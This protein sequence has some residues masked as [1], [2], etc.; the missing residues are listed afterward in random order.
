MVSK[1]FG[2]VFGD[3]GGTKMAVPLRDYLTNLGHEVKFAVDGNGKGADVLK[4]AK[5]NFEVFFGLS[6]VDFTR[7]IKDVDLMFIGTCATALELEIEFANNLL[8]YPYGEMEYD[9]IPVVL[10]ADGLFN[11][12]LKK[13][14][15]VMADYWL[16]ITEGHAQTI[17]ALR[18]DF[19]PD[20]VI[21]AGQPAFDVAMD[22]IPRKEEIRSQRRIEL[23]MQNKKAILWWSTGLGEIIKED[24]EMV[25]AVIS[26]LPQNAVF[27]PRFHPKLEDT[28]RKGY[29]N[30][31][32]TEIVEHCRANKVQLVFDDVTR[33][34]PSEELCLAVDGIFSVTCTEDVKNTMMGGP[35]VVHLM[36]PVVR[37]FY[38]E[39][40]GLKPPYYFPDV[41]GKESLLVIHPNDI[42]NTLS[43]ALRPET[44]KLL[45]KDWQPPKE[46]A[47]VKVA[48]TLLALVR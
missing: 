27:M 29:I 41:L 42:A 45:R 46:K 9:H 28:V 2:F 31:I 18:P 37:E 17:R 8:R 7:F 22:L 16:A 12:G 35:L 20:K 1:R 3:I 14:Q 13:W 30:E 34:I 47:T 26:A 38:E 43:L 4:E 36:G 24:V 15:A 25:K 21:F 32:R 23:E 44:L 40:W 33:K 6:Q 10:G 11:H 48:E 19:S 5:I 39:E